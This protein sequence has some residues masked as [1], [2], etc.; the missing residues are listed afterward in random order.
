[1]RLSQNQLNSNVLS[2]PKSRI[3]KS[4]GVVFA[5]AI[6]SNIAL[7]NP[8]VAL[9][10]LEA[11]FVVPDGVNIDDSFANSLVINQT[12]ELAILNW[13]DFSIDTGNTVQF[14]HFLSDGTTLN[15][16]AATFNFVT[17]NNISYI[18][19][20]LLANG[21]VYLFN[22][23]GV[24]FGSSAMV[25]VGGIFVS[26]LTPDATMD[27]ETFA[28]NLVNGDQVLLENGNDAGSIIVDS[29]QVEFLVDKNL[30]FIGN[31]ISNAGT[32][33]IGADGVSVAKLNFFSGNEATVQLSDSLFEIGV[34][35]NSALDDNATIDN[36][37]TIESRNQSSLLAVIDSRAAADIAALA[38]NNEGVIEA[39]S[40]QITADNKIFLG[41]T[42]TVDSLA[43]TSMSGDVE[44][45]KGDGDGIN[46]SESISIEA[47]QG[48]AR[49]IDDLTT[50]N[51]LSI[52]AQRIGL[53]A[54]LSVTGEDGTLSI[55]SSNTLNVNNSNL[56]AGGGALDINVTGGSILQG[57]ESVLSAA[58][59]TLNASGRATLDGTLNAEQGLAISTGAG[60]IRLIN[61]VTVADSLTLNSGA[62]ISLPASLTVTGSGGLLSIT[63]SNTL[64]L[65]QLNVANGSLD[66]N[67]LGGSILQGADS[68][69]TANA[70][71]L[72]ASGRVTLDGAVDIGSELAI[73]TLL[74]RIE[75]ANDVS[76]TDM[77]S[78]YS[79]SD[80]SLPSSLSVTGENGTLMLNTSESLVLNNISSANLMVDI[81]GELSQSDGTAV[82]TGNTDITASS[83]T[84]GN[85]NNDFDSLSLNSAGNATL[86]DVDRVDLGNTNVANLTLSS[87]GAIDQI[88]GTA[89]STGNA[90][91][92]AGGRIRLGNMVA[93][94]LFASSGSGISQIAGTALD[95][96]NASLTGTSITLENVDN[97][98]DVLALQSSGAAVIRDT[99]DTTL[100][101][102]D[103]NSLMLTSEGLLS[104]TAGTALT[105]DSAELSASSIILINS[106]NDFSTLALRSTGDAEV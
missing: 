106:G 70:A 6:A 30:T 103:V 76:A 88:E 51:S 2:T 34:T 55:T 77:I 59:M 31:G 85:D 104:Q 64:N 39:S 32:L 89:V 86:N 63:S 75:I 44:V 4:V 19:G 58:N 72:D 65:T 10:E 83:I 100:G 13:E 90:S 16:N 49:I 8:Q 11:N 68:G 17:G 101:N 73:T 36:Q 57:T 96:S 3:A 105:A 102:V 14:N 52:T 40:L 38:V 47:T 56:S 27:R 9:P 80:I 33:R 7:A 18:F 12:V 87:G 22:H 46:A 99:G 43:L 41:N 61:D 84:L 71:E 98:F 35:E 67:V 50:S 25:D 79:G 78:L 91:L 74:G 26:T 28:T 24:V 15:N 29:D 82:L 95:I 62:G 23:N 48:A 53:P 37:G 1:M 92:T 93:D 5:A 54:N 66:I 69:I 45:R 20:D 60:N 81:G 21:N 94:N 97:D 42:V